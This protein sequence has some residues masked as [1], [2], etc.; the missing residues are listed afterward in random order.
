MVQSFLR[1]ISTCTLDYTSN[2]YAKKEI[3]NIHIMLFAIFVFSQCE[4]S[5]NHASIRMSFIKI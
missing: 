5:N 4:P 1:L 2:D 3:Y